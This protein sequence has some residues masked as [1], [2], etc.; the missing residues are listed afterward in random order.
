M[1][2]YRIDLEYEGTRYH[3]WQE[4]KS[5]RSILGELRRAVID[6]GGDVVDIGGSGR[7]DA[8]V[9]AVGQ[10]A[11]LR[12][13]RPVDAMPFRAAVNDTL[14]A[15]IHVL[16]ILRASDAFHARHDAVA[17][18]Y[19]YQI[20]RRRTAL[21]K[22]HVWWVR[23]ALNLERMAA[24]ATA[25]RG[26]HDFAAFCERP[27]EQGDTRVKLERA[28]LAEAGSLILVRLVASHFLWKMVRRVVGVLARA[29]GD[30]VP[31]EAL[32]DLLQ[33]RRVRGIEEG[34]AQW[35]APPSGLFLERV[36]YR[37]EL[38]L[39]PLAPLSPVSAE[40]RA[41]EELYLGAGSRGDE[42]GPRAGGS[43]RFGAPAGPGMARARP[44]AP[45]R[46][47]P[48]RRRR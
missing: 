26:L 18:S 10:T 12:L 1:A 38:P 5:A 19:V 46:R 8:G 2:T 16:S 3:G 44:S 47:P 15:D 27:Q 41:G 28:E 24:A 43:T 39:P 20:S 35:T 13:R 29:G 7:T 30:D 33:G 23:R 32:A 17:R 9:H 6:A 11:H 4:Q 25:L 37:G 40:R 34:I 21:G 31:V 45:S 22:R 14:P 42:P 48:P 36:L